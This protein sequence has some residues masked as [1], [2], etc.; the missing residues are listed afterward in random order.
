M[1]ILWKYTIWTEAAAFL[2]TALLSL[3]V[4]A[5][6]LRIYLLACVPSCVVWSLAKWNLSIA[7]RP[8]LLALQ[9]IAVVEAVCLIHNGCMGS[10]HR[11]WFSG[12]AA[13]VGISGSFT[14]Q[15]YGGFP[16]WLFWT[17]LW[18]NLASCA[19]CLGALFLLMWWCPHRPPRWSLWS[20]GVMAL[21]CAIGVF[22]MLY[23]KVQGVEGVSASWVAH[24]ATVALLK[25]FCLFCWSGVFWLSDSRDAKPILDLG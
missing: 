10:R 7:A 22:G 12:S 23:G 25:V 14:A 11:L 9:C 20:V 1:P 13:L 2:A 21:Y 24:D 15:T 8:L 18:A 3:R 6:W 16:E 5:P 17:E 19:V 4:R